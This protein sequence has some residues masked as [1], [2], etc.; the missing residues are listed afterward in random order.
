MAIKVSTEQVGSV[1]DVLKTPTTVVAE[2]ISKV[3]TV[4]EH[5]DN[6]QIGSVVGN[7]ADIS[8]VALGIEDVKSVSSDLD[9]LGIMASSIS[10]I[11]AVAN[12]LGSVGAI[13]S[14]MV[15]LLALHDDLKIFIL[16]WP[17]RNLKFLKH[18]F[19]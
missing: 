19:H 3:N 14:S 6:G 10:N 8:A 1:P 16:F 17:I 5:I 11:I 18:H 13:N 12:N 4:A 2:N 7:E 15:E 9:K